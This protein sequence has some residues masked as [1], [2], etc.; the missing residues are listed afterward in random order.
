MLFSRTKIAFDIGTS[1]TRIGIED[2][3]IVLREP[4][5]VGQNTRSN[6]L[7]FYGT[8]AKE[9]YGKAPGYIKVIKPIENSIISDF[10]ATVYLVQEFLKKAVYP[11][12]AKSFIK[13]GLEAYAVV[14]T[15]STEVEQKALIEALIKAGC[16]KT[17][18]I[19]KPLATAYGAGLP[20]FGH[21]PIFII[22]LGA[23]TIEAT[24]I[25]MGGIVA[26]KV[27]K[28][29]GDHM[30]K[31]IYNYLHLKYGLV[32]GEQTAE[33]LKI[34]L[35]NLKD[36]KDMLP[37]RGKSLENGLPKSVRVTST[38]IQEALSVPLNQ[39]VDGVKELIESAPPEIIDG[40]IK[41]GVTLAGSLAYIPG[42]DK[43]I[44]N[45]IKIPVNIASK[46]EDSTI[47]GLMKIMKDEE[48]LK[49]IIINRS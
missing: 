37:T 17:H 24:I 42:I 39:I 16:H 21:K 4:T 30:D 7:I 10:D 36:Q 6:E 19:E 45:D 29:G 11:Y 9:I 27:L 49:K 1:M 22:D 35:Y 13:Q 5:F 3:G 18:L 31:L 32:I 41:S 15:S 8:D 20:I 14:P 48:N 33:H 40:M 46:P 34:K 2:K 26:S 43:Y 38:D 28:L 47:L 12:Y 23:G 25:I 44:A